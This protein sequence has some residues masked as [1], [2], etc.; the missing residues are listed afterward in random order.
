MLKKWKL[1]RKEAKE[2]DETF[3]DWLARL[4]TDDRDLDRMACSMTAYLES[5][6]TDTALFMM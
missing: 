6:N 4:L 1:I 3:S 5:E 2:Q